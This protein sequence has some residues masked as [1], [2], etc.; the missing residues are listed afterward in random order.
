MMRPP[1]R[2]TIAGAKARSAFAVPVRLTSSWSCQSA[3]SISSSGL[4]A[5]IPALAN[6]TSIPP[7]MCSIVPA[8]SRSR[9][10]LR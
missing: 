1:P 5:W 4:K 2:R 9:A 8:A 10:M 6:R 3:S 7:N